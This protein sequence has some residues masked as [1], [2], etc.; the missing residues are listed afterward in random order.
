MSEQARG[1]QEAGAGT[2]PVF[3]R[4]VTEEQ[5]DEGRLR[6]TWARLA[7]RPARPFDVAWDVVR[8]GK[9]APLRPQVRPPAVV[10]SRLRLRAAY[11]ALP[12][13]DHLHLLLP[14][15]GVEASSIEVADHLDGDY[16]ADLR[17]I[18]IECHHPIDRIAF[19]LLHEFGH[20]IDHEL[21][22]DRDRAS[23]AHR[24]GVVGWR[25]PR[26]DW[27]ERGEEWF[28]ESFAH[29]W[30]PDRLEGQRPGWRLPVPPLRPVIATR[31][32]DLGV[33]RRRS[34]RRR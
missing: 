22:D 28:A 21:L 10:D 19:T 31:A 5:P 14:D 2:A 29:W 27:E 6:R 13:L 12:I 8:T 15:V 34:R 20:A 16:H 7:A 1:R 30:W 18:R 24:Q 25:E 23:L 26:L 3:E 9:A 4:P 17:L 11:E 32:F 33:L